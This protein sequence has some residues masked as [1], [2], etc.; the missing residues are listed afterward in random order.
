L[1]CPGCVAPETLP[2]AGGRA[3]GVGELIDALAFMPDIEGI[4]LSGGE[5]MSQAMA[6]VHLVDGVKARRDLSVVC[7]TGHKVEEL[8]LWGTA[9]Q[10]AL[11]DRIDVLIDGPYLRDHHSDLRW[12]GSDNQRVH[13][14][15]LRYRH[16]AP[17]AED[18]G[19][20]LEVEFDASGGLHWMGI[21]PPRFRGELER[22]LRA[23]G[24]LL[25]TG[26]R[27]DERLA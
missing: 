4:T 10:R 12:R 21:P 24:I 13:F 14:L 6:L 17:L 22:R 7:F 11:L 3:V 25:K 15:S 27:T 8:R 9:A 19:T 16:L 5:P 2:F 18:R 26:G 20:W 1:R 23:A